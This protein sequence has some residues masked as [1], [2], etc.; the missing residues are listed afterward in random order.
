MLGGQGF[1]NNDA[2]LKLL[3]ITY[4]VDSDTNSIVIAHQVPDP[5]MQRTYKFDDEPENPLRA[6]LARGT[7]SKSLVVTVRS[8]SAKSHLIRILTFACSCT[9]PYRDTSKAKL[10]IGDLDRY[11]RSRLVGQ[12]GDETRTFQWR[13]QG[14]AI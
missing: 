4:S 7:G 5:Q 12:H 2:I 6:L 10:N 9:C 1:E 3:G 13:S 11:H 14:E 8:V